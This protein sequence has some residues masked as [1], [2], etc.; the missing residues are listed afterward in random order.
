MSTEPR[1]AVV[2]VLVT[3]PLEID[4][5]DWCVGHDQDRAEYKADVLHCGPDVSLVF[6]GHDIADAGLV[7]APFAERSSRE[8]GVSVSLVGQ[9]LDA[10]GL[11]ELADGLDDYAERLRLL[12]AELE[13]VLGSEG[14]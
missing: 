5:P 12:A 6:R 7:Q 11:R 13:R 3:K 1:I 14:P 2:K 8:P 10:A 4:E 9:T